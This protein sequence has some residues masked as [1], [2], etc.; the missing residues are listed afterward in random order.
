MKRTIK[1]LFAA[2]T[3]FLALTFASIGVSAFS[4]KTKVFAAPSELT[5]EFLRL[6]GAQDNGNNRYCM[7]F[8]TDQTGLGNEFWNNNTAILISAD[9][10]QKE[11]T[12]N[13]LGSGTEL[14]CYL[15]YDQFVTGATTADSVGG[16]YT[17]YFP[18]G[19]KI[20][21]VSTLKND[22]AISVNKYEMTAL[23]V[24]EYAFNG[25][26]AQPANSR[27]LIRFKNAPSVW[28]V[29]GTVPVKLDGKTKQVG[30]FVALGD[31]DFALLLSFD[32]CANGTAHTIEFLAGT[33]S[34]GTYFFK[35][36]TTVWIKADD[37][38]TDSDPTITEKSITLENAKIK[39]GGE[40]SGAY[41]AFDGSWE[42]AG[43]FVNAVETAGDIYVKYNIESET[44]TAGG[45]YG[46][47]RLVSANTAVHYAVTHGI[48]DFVHNGSVK[49]W[50]DVANGNEILRQKIW[51]T[52]PRRNRSYK[53]VGAGEE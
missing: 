39:M 49:T 11:I 21:G 16:P 14:A 7:T 32:G 1:I 50:K 27:Y 9:G 48:V 26:G 12:M 44:R 37:S 53:K 25:G 18:A 38:I 6:D 24:A 22:V 30:D 47:T 35:N 34:G 10:T 36:G 29:Y 42:N 31:G 45:T 46:A 17:L 41:Y 15:T 40:Y 20:G 5:M 51:G 4:Q 2:F 23:T 13:F 33:P 8:S 3:A 43:W 28:T 52:D 19:T